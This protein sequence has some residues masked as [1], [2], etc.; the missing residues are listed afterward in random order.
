MPPASPIVNSWHWARFLDGA[1]QVCSSSV[2][3]L[4]DDKD[5]SQAHPRS[6]KNSIQKPSAAAGPS[7]PPSGELAAPAARTWP[8]GSLPHNQARQGAGGRNG[9]WQE[10][11]DSKFRQGT[12][13]EIVGDI[14]SFNYSG[15]ILTWAN[16]LLKTI[17]QTSRGCYPWQ[18]PPQ[19]ALSRGA[20]QGWTTAWCLALL[21]HQLLIANELNFSKEIRVM[22]FCLHTDWMTNKDDINKTILSFICGWTNGACAQAKPGMLP[23]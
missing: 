4:D 18:L 19:I 6:K 7:R 12:F 20:V 17:R 11:E 23:T 8:R 14:I 2:P 13:E 22:L 3:W 5:H 9:L 10:P 16:Y 1:V 15:I 21:L